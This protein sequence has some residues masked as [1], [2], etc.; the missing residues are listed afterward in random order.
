MNKLKSIVKSVWANDS[1]RR[2]V[3]TFWQTFVATLVVSAAGAHD[4]STAKGAV[5]A[6]AAAGLAAVKAVLVAKS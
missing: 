5:L 1:V 6:A 3:H 2:V 4:L